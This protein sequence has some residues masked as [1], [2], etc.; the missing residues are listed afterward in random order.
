[1]NASPAEKRYRLNVGVV[2]FNG[3][4]KVFIGRRADAKGPHIWQFPQGGV[5]RGE[6]LVVAAKRELWE[7]TGIKSVAFLARAPGWITYDFPEGF[8]GAKAMRGY[9]GQ[10]QAWFAFRFL[11]EDAEID[12]AHHVAE[13]DAWRWADLEETPALVV[14]FKREAYLKVVQAFRPMA[15]GE[16]DAG[17]RGSILMIHGV[18][19]T[20]AAFAPLAEDFRTRGWRVET[21]TLRADLRGPRRPGP[22][23]GEISLSD[24]VEEACGWAK[25][26]AAETG[27][28]P[29]VLG[30]SM[31]GL[32]AQKLLERGLGRAGVLLAPAQPAGLPSKPTASVAFT[33][34]NILLS[35]N[36]RGRAFKIWRPGFDWGVLN[37]V[38]KENRAAVYA[39]A[40]YDSG[41]VYADLIAPETAQ[42]GAARI[43]ADAIRAPILTIAGAKD[44]ATPPAAV[45]AVSAKYAAVG[46]AFREYP[47]HAHWLIDEPGTDRLA[48]DI[49]AWL[50]RTLV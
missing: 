3:E 8:R 26:L 38:P 21:P 12:L 28:A 23:L 16:P 37:A 10:T 42:N 45:R 50:M 25:A 5:D 47:D 6:D 14:D 30:H 24:Y 2:V 11:G 44:R 49:D 29:V 20:G 43:E 32:I 9:A 1:M 4:G 7:E 34:A 41:Q 39:G 18:G 31:G 19:C 17:R 22:G 36:K 13:F 40:V 27:Q 48:A 46:G 35:P 33:F 15:A